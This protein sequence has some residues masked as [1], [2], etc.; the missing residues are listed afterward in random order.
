MNYSASPNHLHHN[1]L[2]PLKHVAGLLGYL[3]PQRNIFQTKFT[4]STS[5]L[6]QP[7]QPQPHCCLSKKTSKWALWTLPPYKSQQGEEEARYTP[8]VSSRHTSPGTLYGL[9]RESQSILLVLF[10]SSCLAPPQGSLHLSQSHSLVPLEFNLTL[11]SGREFIR[12]SSTAHQTA[13]IPTP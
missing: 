7:Q 3:I 4:L 13:S 12:N 10:P 2:T 9:L 1:G 11:F 8:S 5:S 6:C